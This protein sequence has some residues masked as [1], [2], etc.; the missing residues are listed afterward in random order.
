MRAG[1]QGTGL[2]AAANERGPTLP[3]GQRD[4][5]RTT[6][7]MPH[8]VNTGPAARD[9]ANPV[10][11]PGGPAAW[12]GKSTHQRGSGTLLIKARNDW[13]QK[14]TQSSVCLYGRVTIAWSRELIF[15]LGKL[16]LFIYE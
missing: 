12:G 8:S 7:A 15:N 2:W 9:A 16:L 4:L 5:G 11:S 1:I 3:A 6:L 14:T 10:P 13:S